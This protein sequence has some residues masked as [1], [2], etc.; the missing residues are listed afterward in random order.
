MTGYYRGVSQRTENT[1]IK[2][3]VKRRENDK[4]R[5]ATKSVDAYSRG[6]DVERLSNGNIPA[7]AW[8]PL[9]R[10]RYINPKMEVELVNFK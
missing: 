7:Y 1:G 10:E 2:R 8:G 9:K 3:F 4:Q 6:L 5:V